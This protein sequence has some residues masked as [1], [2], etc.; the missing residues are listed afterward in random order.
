MSNTTPGGTEDLTSTQDVGISTTTSA[1]RGVPVRIDKF[2]QLNSVQAAPPNFE[3][4]VNTTPSHQRWRMHKVI[5]GFGAFC[6]IA[7][8]IFLAL[9]DTG[10]L[11]DGVLRCPLGARR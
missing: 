5:L 6:N 3:P 4:K 7:L 8:M 1:P 11:G 9:V 2:L 10:N